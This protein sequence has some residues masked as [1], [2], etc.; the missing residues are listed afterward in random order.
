[1][2][3]TGAREWWKAHR[4]RRIPLFKRIQAIELESLREQIPD[5]MRRDAAF[6]TL[7]RRSRPITLR[8]RA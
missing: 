6:V 8:S 1:M 2:K 7:F 3:Y 5:L 4:K